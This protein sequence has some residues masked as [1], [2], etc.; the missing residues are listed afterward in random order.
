MAASLVKHR[1][2]TFVNAEMTDG[3]IG[4]LFLFDLLAPPEWHQ[5]ASWIVKI[6]IWLPWLNLPMFFKG[7]QN[8]HGIGDLLSLDVDNVAQ[9]HQFQLVLLGN[10]D[11]GVQQSRVHGECHLVCCYLVGFHGLVQS[12]GNFQ[13]L[14]F[15]QNHVVVLRQSS[16]NI[17]GIAQFG[18][19]GFGGFPHLQVCMWHLD[20]KLRRKDGLVHHGGS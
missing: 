6:G 14:E 11:F 17:L 4:F 2:F 19:L 5:W 13:L 10:F 15:H 9:W 12:H 18:N 3:H 7:C 1:I 8:N 16:F 20:G